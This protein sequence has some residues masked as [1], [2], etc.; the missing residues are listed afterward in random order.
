M[1]KDHGKAAFGVPYTDENGKVRTFNPDWIVFFKD[2]KIGIFD[3]KGG[4]TAEDAGP[5][6]NGLQAWLRSEA[7]RNLDLQLV[8]GIVIYHSGSWKLFMEEEYVYDEETLPDGWQLYDT[9]LGQTT[10]E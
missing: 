5:R 8:G 1:N 6:S 4:K 10:L 2:G 3:T 7:V 9:L